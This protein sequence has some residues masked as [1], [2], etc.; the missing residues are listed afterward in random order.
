M[1]SVTAM[2]FESSAEGSLVSKGGNR[3]WDLRGLH[4]SVVSVRGGGYVTFDAVDWLISV[5][6]SIAREGPISWSFAPEP[7]RPRPDKGGREDGCLDLRALSRGKT[8]TGAFHVRF[9]DRQSVSGVAARLP[10]GGLRECPEGGAGALV[11]RDRVRS[12]LLA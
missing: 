9:S 4:Y 7:S 1:N 5:G 10:S 11:L 6:A 2:A 8:S 3:T 12:C